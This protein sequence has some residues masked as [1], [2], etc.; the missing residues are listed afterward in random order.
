MSIRTAKSFRPT[1]DA[2]EARD[3]MSCLGFS[4][5]SLSPIMN[6]PAASTS[7]DL[8]HEIVHAPENGAGAQAPVTHS[9]IAI[10]IG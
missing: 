9:I 8:A 5:S 1:F 2:L 6:P 4:A 3:N 7:P 10:L